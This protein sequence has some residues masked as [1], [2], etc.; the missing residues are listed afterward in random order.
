MQVCA[1]AEA[2]D[3]LSNSVIDLM[4]AGEFDEAE[5]AGHQLLDRY[6]DEVDGLE[7]LA[8]V[9]E[10]KGRNKKAAEYYRKAADFMRS[11]SGFDEEAIDWTL[12]AA[13]RL[14]SAD[15]DSRKTRL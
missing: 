3:N 8:M 4:Q 1:E 2:L 12:K 10:A 14:E 11:R 5:K 13:A 7:R 6:P 15:A 9:Y